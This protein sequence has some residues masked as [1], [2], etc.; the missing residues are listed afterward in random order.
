MRHFLRIYPFIIFRFCEYFFGDPT[1]QG[2]SGSP[3]SALALWLTFLHPG[4]LLV[5]RAITSSR[6]CCLSHHPLFRYSL[7]VQWLLDGRIYL[8]LFG[9]RPGRWRCGVGLRIEPLLR[10]VLTPS[11]GILFSVCLNL[12]HINLYYAPVVFMFLL[13]SFCIPYVQGGRRF[14]VANF[15]TLGFSVIFIFALSLGPFIVVRTF[16]YRGVL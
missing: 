4:L 14:L 5:D 12:K 15:L 7:P 9:I 11:S 16:S 10:P 2:K 6:S 13:S 8:G 3:Y 1:R